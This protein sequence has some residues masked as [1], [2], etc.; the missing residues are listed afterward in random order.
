[1]QRQAPYLPRSSDPKSVSVAAGVGAPIPKL[2][3]RR[4]HLR[5]LRAQ[6]LHHPA[7]IV[8]NGRGRWPQEHL[9][10]I[11]A[12]IAD[13]RAPQVVAPQRRVRTDD[14]GPEAGRRPDEDGGQ[15]RTLASA[16]RKVLAKAIDVDRL[17]AAQEN[18]L[19]TDP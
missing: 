1:C 9:L 3:D 16:R 18:Q 8:R 19:L 14:P 6:P 7:A 5:R 2:F 4:G 13:G 15:V 12:L 10:Q 17:A 11:V